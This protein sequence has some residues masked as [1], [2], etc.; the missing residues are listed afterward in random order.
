MIVNDADVEVTS[1]IATIGEQSLLD[2]EY[3]TLIEKM[4][5][6]TENL[7][8]ANAYK[9][10]LLSQVINELS[11]DDYQKMK[12]WIERM[13]ARWLRVDSRA[14]WN[15]NGRLVIED[16]RRNWI[17]SYY[18]NES[19]ELRLQKDIYF[20]TDVLCKDYLLTDSETYKQ[21][22][23][24]SSFDG[25]VIPYCLDFINDV[26]MAR[27]GSL[28]DKCQKESNV[29]YNPHI[30]KGWFEKMIEENFQLKPETRDEF[31]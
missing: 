7:P 11:E 2:I 12:V 18:P 21:R 25:C 6:Y 14:Q 8:Q 1:F 20:A 23:I 28:I 16:I 10:I 3:H 9:N 31:N 4:L 30:D 26:T 24:I 22:M 27:Y 19:S 29:V 5:V 13:A 15:F 17:I